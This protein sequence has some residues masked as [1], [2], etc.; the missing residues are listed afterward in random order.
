MREFVYSIRYALLLVIAVSVAIGFLL[1]RSG[2]SETP[3]SKRP[4]YYV[5]LEAGGAKPDRLS[6]ETGQMIEFD[7]RDGNYHNIVQVTDPDPHAYEHVSSGYESGVF[8]PDEGYQATFLKA[9]SYIFHDHL[10][11]NIVIY[12]D[13][14]EP[15][16]ARE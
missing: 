4:D 14:H 7:A 15:K 9:G 5:K 13:V 10:H 16:S 6:I 2:N 8:A 11:K 12:V 1:G 3:Q